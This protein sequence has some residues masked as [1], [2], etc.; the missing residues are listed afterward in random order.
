MTYL[1]SH[2]RKSLKRIDFWGYST[3]LI[4]AVQYRRT[5]F[6]PLWA[7]LNPLLFS[8]AL[9]ALYGRVSGTPPDIFIPHM[10]VG[11]V[12]WTL[13]AEIV[14]RASGLL[15][16]NKGL[17]LQ[18]NISN[19]D[20]I[21][22]DL[23]YSFL[24]FAHQL[25]I[26]LGVSLFFGHLTLTGI[27]LTTLG[28]IFYL[29]NGIWVMVVLGT[30]AARFRDIPEVVSAI[31]RIAFLASPILWM[32]NLEGLRTGGMIEAYTIYNPFYH[33][34]EIVRAPMLEK[35]ID[36]ISYPVVITITLVGFLIAS[37]VYA[38]TWRQTN[39]WI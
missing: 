21:C 6:G 24:S 9:G 37:V 20:I 12:A 26:I 1:W 33:F 32:A 13:L 11:L 17:L 25:P 18:G 3:W 10:V 27:L 2:L 14:N 36:P 29:L 22:K 30:I 31:M 34:L 5:F 4:F 7:L 23:F 16:A 39:L 35:T 19:T 15:V 28:T 38:K 8:L